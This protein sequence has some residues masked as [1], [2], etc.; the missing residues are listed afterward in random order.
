M[1]IF[2][3]NSLCKYEKFL[4]LVGGGSYSMPGV[5]SGG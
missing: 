3:V 1:V 5:S 2:I 4:G